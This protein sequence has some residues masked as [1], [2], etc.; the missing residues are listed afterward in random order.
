[1]PAVQ[2]AGRQSDIILVD[3]KFLKFST[4]RIFTEFNE[5]TTSFSGKVY[6]KQKQPGCKKSARPI[7]SHNGYK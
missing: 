7:R 5:G 2:H 3:L 1:M 6:A 4:S